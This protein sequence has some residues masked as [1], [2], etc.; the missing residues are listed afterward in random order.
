LTDKERANALS[1]YLNK[2]CAST[3]IGH[4]KRSDVVFN[5]SQVNKKFAEFLF[6]MQNPLQIFE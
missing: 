6:N 3:K 2:L 5:A 4:L 1:K